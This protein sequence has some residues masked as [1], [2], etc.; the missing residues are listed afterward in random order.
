[1]WISDDEGSRCCWPGRNF[2]KIN[3]GESLRIEL[4]AMSSMSAG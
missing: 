4:V 2:E 1:M 3:D